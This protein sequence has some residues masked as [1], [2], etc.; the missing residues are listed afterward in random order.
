MEKH[1]RGTIPRAVGEDFW[2][3]TVLK[4]ASF[5]EV[6]PIVSTAR[7]YHVHIQRGNM[8]FLAV[9]HGEAPPLMTIELLERIAN[10]FEDYFHGLNEDVIKDNFVIC[11][12]LLEELVDNGFPVTTEPTILK[13]LI[14]PPSLLNKLKQVAQAPSASKDIG[15][16]ME[17]SPVPWRRAGVKYTNNEIFFDIIEEVDCIIDGNGQVVSSEI[18]GRIEC[19]SRLSGFPD[20]L[21][22]F[23]NPQVMEDM[24]FHQCVRFARYEQDRTLS[25]VPPDGVFELAKYRTAYNNNVPFY[26]TPKL[27]FNKGTGRVNIIVGLKAGGRDVP[28]KG[29]QDVKISVTLPK[30]ADSVRLEASQGTYN[31]DATTK[32]L[33]WD[34][35]RV[36]QN[37]F[38][39]LNGSIQGSAGTEF[40]ENASLSAL[41]DFKLPMIALSTLRIDAVTLVNEK[42]KPY[43]G[44]RPVTKAGRYQVR[45]GG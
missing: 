33:K 27:T 16:S 4:A 3:N 32:E 21:L 25:F 24:A 36:S 2:T 19:N 7:Y 15:Y 43:K 31:F 30:E 5:P 42:Y 22:S 14:P 28:D 44:V 11:Y 20:V 17:N 1:W 39:S 6:M 12:Q 26:V 45:V 37:K 10:L 23:V 29:V 8:F 38:P 34:V 18:T 41:V 40:N 9:L 13:D 35:G